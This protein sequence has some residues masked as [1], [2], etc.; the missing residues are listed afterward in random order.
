MALPRLVSLETLNQLRKIHGSIPAT[1]APTPMKKLCIA[2]PVPC[3]GS[4]NL[5]ATKARKGSIET[6]M[7][8]SRIHSRPAAIQS[9][10]QFGI[11]TSANELKIAPTRKY[12]RRRPSRPQVRSLIAPMMGCTRKPV[13]GAASQSSGICESDAPRY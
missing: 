11:S 8:A 5:S 3:C 2:K 7:L 9:V 13:S 12:G 6:L 4:G 10:L 1:T